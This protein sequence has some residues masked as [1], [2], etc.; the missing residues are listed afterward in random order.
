MTD[1]KRTWERTFALGD[2][3]SIMVRPVRPE[4]RHEIAKALATL[5]EQTT[6]R[7]FFRA[8]V[9]PSD[10]VLDYLT[11]VDQQDHVALIATASSPDMKEE[12]ALG[13]ARFVRLKDDPTVA[14]AAVTVLDEHQRRGIGR[15]LL[16]ELVAVAKRR[17]I[18]RFRAEVLKENDAMLSILAQVGATKVAEADGCATFETDLGEP[19]EPSSAAYA[20]FKTIARLARRA[21]S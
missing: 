2:G 9:D 17:G 15:V 19:D 14:E 11:N 4:D 7:R 6:M 16:E 18:R 5:S 10:E 12:H 13:V 8:H 3:T 1:A 20:L 21:R